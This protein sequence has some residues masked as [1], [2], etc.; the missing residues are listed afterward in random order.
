MSSTRRE[1][2]GT[3]AVAAV[4]AGTVSI[5]RRRARAAAWV[6]SHHPLPAVGKPKPGWSWKLPPNLVRPMAPVRNNIFYVGEHIVFKLGPAATSYAVRNYYGDLV[7]QGPADVVITLKA[8]PPGWYKLYI[9]GGKVT[10]QW[11]DIVGGTMFVVFRNNP[12]FPKPG[13]DAPYAADGSDPVVR[14]V[15]AMGPT[16]LQADATN[17]AATIKTNDQTIALYEK[18]YVHPGDPMRPRPLEMSFGNGTKGH[19]GGVKQ[20]V[21]HFKDRVQYW[22]PRNEP[23]GGAT[24]AGF[25]KDELIDFYNTVKSV[26]PELKVIGPGT[27]AID[28][29]LYPW[30]EDFFKAGGGKYIDAFSFHAY[31]CCNGDLW[32][33]R[34]S[35]TN[36][37]AMLKKYGLENIEKWQTEQ[38][39]FAAVYGAYHPHLQGRWTMLQM[40]VYEQFGIPKEHN[41]L[42]YDMS[43][44]FWDFPTWWENGDHSLNPAAPLMRVWS[45]ELFGT[46]F[47]QAF[48]FGSYANEIYVG[49]L[50]EG[51]GK[52]VATFMTAGDTEGKVHL[53]VAGGNGKLRV[54]SAFGVESDIP[55]VGG[56]AVLAVPEMPVFVELTPGQ[57]LDVIP[58]RWG[59]DSALAKG[60]T[61]AASATGTETAIKA[62]VDIEKIY[63]NH[64]ENWYWSFQG[65]SAPWSE[66]IGKFPIWVRLKIPQVVK[67]RRVILFCAPPWQSQ[68]TLLDFELQYLK[69][70]RWVTLKRVRENPKTIGVFT[71]SVR[72]MVD[73]FFSDRWIFQFDFSPVFTDEIRLLVHQSTWGGSTCELDH[74]AGG[75]GWSQ[76][77]FCIRELRVF[78]V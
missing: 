33:E 59:P 35:L 47:S 34:K 48:D 40:M 61:A 67:M 31:N 60:V 22:E 64:L 17:P 43:H 13:K 76:P 53:Q 70:S 36:L 38:G 44:G 75:Q 56:K 68:G 37:M 2:V 10:K 45:E 72:C 73:V 5:P 9:Y 16:R 58:Y 51:R 62:S 41:D 39:F 55:V 3:M 23:N 63:D 27:V 8:Q 4:A 50:F 77:H 42:W 78:A 15:T 66:N 6:P 52:S 49:S 26:S 54:V 11:G 19:L 20:I 18:Y 32:L 30:L 46:K 57:T 25:V 14:G 7:D 21:E 24:G 69:G 12:H 74:Q 65:P 28:P 71:P 1:F 29:S